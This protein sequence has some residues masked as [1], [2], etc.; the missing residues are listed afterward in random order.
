MAKDL[1]SI[2][3]FKTIGEGRKL[4]AKKREMLNRYKKLC[5]DIISL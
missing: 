2:R 1:R 4:E 3:L 5:K